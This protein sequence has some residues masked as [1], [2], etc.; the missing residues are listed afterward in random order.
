M[1]NELTSWFHRP[2]GLPDGKYELPAVAVAADDS[3]GRAAVLQFSRATDYHGDVG[4]HP[5]D[6]ALMP[7]RVENVV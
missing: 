2:F 5:Q 7:P 4:A 6:A 1:K 3:D